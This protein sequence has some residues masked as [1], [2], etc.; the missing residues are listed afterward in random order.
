MDFHFFF[1]K[2]ANRKF[3]SNVDIAACN[4]LNLQISR[5]ISISFLFSPFFYHFS[6]NYTKEAHKK[7]GKCWKKHLH[8]KNKRLFFSEWT[9]FSLVAFHCWSSYFYS[10]I[11]FD[12]YFHHSYAVSS[13]FGLHIHLVRGIDDFSDFVQ[14]KKLVGFNITHR[15]NRTHMHTHA[16]NHFSGLLFNLS[17]AIMC[18]LYFS[19]YC[20]RKLCENTEKWKRFSKTRRVF[21]HERKVSEEWMQNEKKMHLK[22]CLCEGGLWAYEKWRQK[23]IVGPHFMHLV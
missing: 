5:K 4:N 12:L 3:D 20:P 13:Y 10:I 11:W 19:G 2:F 16:H 1:G 23:M 17:S 8:R 21:C 6:F 9:F 14:N 18:N 15:P 22:K 7:Y